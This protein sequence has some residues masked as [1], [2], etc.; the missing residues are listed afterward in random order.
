MKEAVGVG[1]LLGRGAVGDPGHILLPAGHWQ[2]ML[3]LADYFHWQPRG[4]QATEWT[5]EG[6]DGRYDCGEGQYVTPDDAAAL[7]HALRQAAASAEL[8]DALAGRGESDF[9][10]EC[11]VETALG[12]LGLPSVD[13]VRSRLTE[14][15]EF[16][17]RGGFWLS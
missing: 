1:I 5:P 3:A 6:W 7:A 10:L 14:V 12:Y 8:A 4:T 17:G 11:S 16:C 15:A 9:G 13:A 2:L